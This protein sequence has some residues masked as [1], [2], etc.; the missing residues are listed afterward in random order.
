[1]QAARVR[2]MYSRCADDASYTVRELNRPRVHVT[3]GARPSD[4]RMQRNNVY[5]TARTAFLAA[6]TRFTSGFRALYGQYGTK[7]Y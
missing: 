2:R 7:P 6:P 3:G 5:R 1:M 4:N